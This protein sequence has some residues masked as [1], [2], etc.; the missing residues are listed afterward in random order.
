MTHKC[1]LLMHLYM[2]DPF[3]TDSHSFRRLWLFES[4]DICLCSFISWWIRIC[5]LASAGGHKIVYVPLNN[6]VISHNYVFNFKGHFPP[7]K[8]LFFGKIALTFIDLCQNFNNWIKDIYIDT[9]KLEANYIRALSTSPNFIL[10]TRHN[11]PL[12]AIIL[13]KRTKVCTCMS[14]LSLNSNNWL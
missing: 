7:P 13:P 3:V 11:R 8:K 1:Q 10:S 2:V 5:I 9:L 14:D 4:K 6:S 12:I